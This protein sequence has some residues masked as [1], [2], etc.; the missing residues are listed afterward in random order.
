MIVASTKFGRQDEPA[1]EAQQQQSAKQRWAEKRAEKV[2]AYQRALAAER[3]RKRLGIIFGSVGR[4]A[5][6]ALIVTFIATSAEPKLRP[7]DIE[8]ADLVAFTA[9]PANHVGSGPV[10]YQATYGMNPPAGGDHAQAWLNCG[11]YQQPQQNENAVQSLEHGAVWFTYDP[12]SA[13]EDQIAQLRSAVP[14]TYVIVSPYPGLPAPFVASAWGAQIELD[15]PDDPRLGQ[16]IDKYWQSPAA[17]EPGAACVGAI[18]G[19][20]RVA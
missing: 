9:L 16:F 5:V 15:S 3:R 10:D 18:D 12:E 13:T 7:A 6:L 17:P 20:G 8:I 1:A 14:D 2:Q 4:A 19:P 11:V